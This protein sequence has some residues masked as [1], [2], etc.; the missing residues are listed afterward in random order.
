MAMPA[1][2][3]IVAPMTDAPPQ[4]WLHDL[5][6]DH[7]GDRP[8]ILD[9]DG[10]SLSYADLRALTEQTAQ[11]FHDHGVRPGDRVMLVCENCASYAAA[12]LA[13]S[14][15]K[16]W[17]APVNA[18]HTAE[19]LSAIRDHSG[20]RLMAFTTQ[21]SPAARAHAETFEA[22]KNLPC[23]TLAV[24]PAAESTPEPV[25][26]TAETR[27]AALLYT[28]GTTS[29]PKGVMLSHRN[30]TWNAQSS[31]ELRNITPDDTV[32]AVLPGS[33]IFGFASTMLAT[34]HAGATLQFLPRFDPDAVLDALA[35]GIS[36]MPAVPQM[37]A[38]L[39]THLHETKRP[40]D[41]PRL[42]Y[43]SAGGAPLDPD[44][45][46][47]TEATF[48]IP[49]NNGYGLTETSPGVAGTRPS[50]PRKDT[51]VG[52]P[53]PDVKITIDAPD[54]DGIGEI[55]IR[56]PNV[57]LGYYRDP[58]AT[59][60]ALPEPGL[61]RSGDLGRIDADGC[62]HILGRKKEL[63]IR[64]GFNV[65]P[66]EIEAMLTRHPD[67]L[68]SAVVGR[69]HGPNEEIL[70][71]VMARGTLTEPA[72]RSWL[73]TRLAPYKQP[74][75]LFLVDAFPTA[76]T[77]KILKHRLIPAFQSLITDRDSAAEET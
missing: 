54:T 5:I 42:R 66:P 68:Q 48:G 29:A 76:S 44:L 9:H 4:R 11:G 2:V 70:A 75:H 36:V 32:L 67:V 38:R 12:T 62:L 52:P 33:H 7:P 18:R 39:L 19:E 15:L 17:A 63:I 24:T 57:M 22:N 1:R 20:A 51:S 31:A 28:T 34:F 71:F 13:L 64:S 69:K 27:T 55:L 46:S 61:F 49:L 25:P 73:S 26:E 50:S 16:A 77:G 53:L 8:A 72:L 6:A 59:A 56:G 41:A 47:Q 10:T 45:K 14:R 3:A 37:Y 65:Y 21:A 35:Q 74:Q 30:L 23:D 43:I 40:L 58:H 60:Q